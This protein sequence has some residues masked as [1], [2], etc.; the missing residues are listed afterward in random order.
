M[1]NPASPRV[2]IYARVSTDKQATTNTIASQVEALQ[3]RV[4]ADGL[5]LDAGDYFLDDGYSGGTFD[6][7]ALD[8]LRDLVA[9]GA[10]QRI[11][12]HSPDRLAR[13]YVHQ[14]VLTDEWAAS[15]VEVIFLNRAIGQSPEDQLLLQMQGMMAEY[16]RAKIVERCRRGRKHAA[17]LGLVSALS[18]APYGYRY[19]TKH[20]GGGQARYEIDDEQARIIQQIFAW[21]GIERC[22]LQEVV[23]RLKTRQIPSPTGRPQW[24]AS[25]LGKMLQ[26]TAYRGEA[27]FG[28]TRVGPRRAPLRPHRGQPAHPKQ[29]STRCAGNEQ[30]RT[31]IPV[32]ALVDANLFATVAEQLAENRRRLRAQLGKQ[33]Y[34]LH[35]LLVCANCGYAFYGK[36]I[37]YS[38]A[39]GRKCLTA[40]YRCTGSDRHRF[41][42]QRLCDN[43]QCRSDQLD[44]AVWN[45]VVGLLADPDRIRQEYQR[46]CNDKK[47]AE[48]RPSNQLSRL[49]AQAQNAIKRLI[50]AFEAGLLEKAELEPRLLAARERLARLEAE[51]EATLQRETEENDLDATISQL[52]TLAEKIG[53]GLSNADWNTRQSIL[54]TLIKQ[55]EIGK[56]AIRIVYKVKPP[57]DQSPAKGHL[58]QHC[59]RGCDGRRDDFVLWIPR[60]G[61]PRVS[62][63]RKQGSNPWWC[64]I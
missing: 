60:A 36:P 38:L 27:K 5:R 46:R 30:E 23:R 3:S 48:A 24:R 62:P 11:Y 56:D 39:N 32:P 35:G 2:A 25:T 17:Q 12:V 19:I 13:N 15:G 45:D 29:Q 6:R 1:S 40:Y 58:L 37:S 8:R 53:A 21:V 31:D 9:A 28:K 47:Q 41:G 61:M 22:S 42:G 44:K 57:F 16:E 26:N 51:R 43:H 64:P 34:L 10:V 52:A 49:I 33:R 55:V 63:R 4:Q 14:V 54:R 20:A 18:V 7:P 50:D 59:P